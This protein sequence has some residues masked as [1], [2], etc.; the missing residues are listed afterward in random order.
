M[1]CGIS[2]KKHNNLLYKGY[3]DS[4]FKFDDEVQNSKRR[5][6]HIRQ[7]GRR[8][9]RHDVVMGAVYTQFLITANLSDSSSRSSIDYAEVTWL[10]IRFVNMQIGI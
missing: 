2:L 4:L 3:Q 1:S 6:Y 8:K 5:E 9:L 10:I 7:Y